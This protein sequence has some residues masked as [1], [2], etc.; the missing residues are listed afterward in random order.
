MIIDNKYNLRY[1]KNDYIEF[2]NLLNK[3]YIKNFK[4]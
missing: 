1:I 3:K 2:Q 4:I